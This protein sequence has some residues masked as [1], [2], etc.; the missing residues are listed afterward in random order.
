MRNTID[1]HSLQVGNFYKFVDETTTRRIEF[2][3]YVCRAAIDPFCGCL[4]YDVAIL[5]SNDN[6]RFINSDTA[7]AYIEVAEYKGKVYHL[8]NP[9][10]TYDIMEPTTKTMALGRRN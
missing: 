2:I 7:M 3:G 5:Q 10:L 1:I 6:E 9:K 4:N 8:D